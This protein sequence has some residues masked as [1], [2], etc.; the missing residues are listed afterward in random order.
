MTVQ[1]QAGNLEAA[2]RYGLCSQEGGRQR[3]TRAPWAPFEALDAAS[4]SAGVTYTTN[5]GLSSCVTDVQ[6]PQYT[7]GEI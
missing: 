5:E 2:P 4:V 1:S 3:G 7:H 6:A